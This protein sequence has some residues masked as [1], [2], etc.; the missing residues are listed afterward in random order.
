MNTINR[1]SCI[2]S[3]EIGSRSKE[4]NIWIR[5]SLSKFKEVSILQSIV[6]NNCKL[7]HRGRFHDSLFKTCYFK[8]H[9]ESSV[10]LLWD[11]FIVWW[12][13]WSIEFSYTLF[14]TF[15]WKHS[16]SLLHW[17][18]NRNTILQDVDSNSNTFHVCRMEGIQEGLSKHRGA[19][20][21]LTPGHRKGLSEFKS[22]FV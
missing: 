10:L 16:L 19:H 17:K 9:I 11:V 22:H 6:K 2:S 7:E 20:I 12:L 4:K 18:C 21:A 13:D 5:N 1:Y 8:S 14:V 15:L 3:S